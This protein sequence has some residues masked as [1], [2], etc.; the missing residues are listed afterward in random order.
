MVKVGTCELAIAELCAG[1]ARQF[2][3]HHMLTLGASV[4]PLHLRPGHH[5]VH[6]AQ[7]L[8][9]IILIVICLYV[10]Y[11]LLI[12]QLFCKISIHTSVI[13]SLILIYCLSTKV[14]FVLFFT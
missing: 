12:L 3:C 2:L 9:F 5:L 6:G 4:L 8:D 13:R 7:F 14:D 1:P 10:L 11:V